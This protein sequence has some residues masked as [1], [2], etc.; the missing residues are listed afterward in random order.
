MAYRD[1]PGGPINALANTT[2]IYQTI[3]NAT[4]LNEKLTKFQI[5][6]VSIGIACGMII[7][8]GDEIIACVTG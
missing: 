3:I 4:F 6:G 8:A 2:S 5:I 7:S 1:G